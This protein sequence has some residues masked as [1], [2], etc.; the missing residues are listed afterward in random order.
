MFSFEVDFPAALPHSLLKCRVIRFVYILGL[1]RFL[2]GLF[3]S[4]VVCKK[5]L[6]YLIRKNSTLLIL[7]K[8]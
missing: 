2:L 4:L 8:S 7:V 6:P 5:T 1:G 3:L